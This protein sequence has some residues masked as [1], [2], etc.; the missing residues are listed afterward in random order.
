VLAAAGR[1]A[2]ARAELERAVERFESIGDV[3]EAERTRGLLVEL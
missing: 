1:K 3:F 2:E